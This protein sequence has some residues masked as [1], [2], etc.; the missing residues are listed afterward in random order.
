MGQPSQN[1][2]NYHL[3]SLKNMLSLFVIYEYGCHF[4]SS[5]F[6]NLLGWQWRNFENR[7]IFSEDM[8]KM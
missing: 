4:V 7:S 2:S 6:S 1:S 3:D 5:W 8:D